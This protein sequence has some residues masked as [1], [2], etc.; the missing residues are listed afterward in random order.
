VVGNVAI[1]AAHQSY[2]NSGVAMLS[3]YC[4][5]DVTFFDN[6]AHESVIWKIY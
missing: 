2:E 4:G 6:A 3:F 1:Y 5:N